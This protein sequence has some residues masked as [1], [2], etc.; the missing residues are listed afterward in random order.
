MTLCMNCKYAEL[1]QLYQIMDNQE[2]T[3][4]RYARWAICNN[5]TVTVNKPNYITGKADFVFIGNSE[6]ISNRECIHLNDGNC[7]GYEEKL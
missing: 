6:C 4:N 5:K 3:W 1:Y 7:K 2:K